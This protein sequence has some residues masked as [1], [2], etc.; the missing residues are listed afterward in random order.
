MTKFEYYKDT[1]EKLIKLGTGQL[2]VVK[3]EPRICRHL[4]C[5]VC[6]L[7]KGVFSDCKLEFVK[8]LLKEHIEKPK[9]TKRERKLC[10]VLET[11]WIAAEK[12]GSV[13]W[14]SNLPTKGNYSYESDGN[15]LYLNGAGFMFDFINFDDEEPWSVKDLLRLEVEE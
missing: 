13:Y 2:E 1:I 7:N 4:D 15:S 10:E 12:S 11:G 3:D 5:A 8:W 9:L 6:D 14:Y